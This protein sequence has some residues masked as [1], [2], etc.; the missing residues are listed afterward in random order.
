MITRRKLLNSL[1]FVPLAGALAAY[2]KSRELTNEEKELIIA[3][4]LNTNEG[5]KALAEA[6][7]AP[8]KRRLL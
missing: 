3:R 1:F 6:M 4:A 7:I 8:I 5:R 2:K